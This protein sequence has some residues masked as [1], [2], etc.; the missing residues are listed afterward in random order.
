[1]PPAVLKTKKKPSGVRPAQGGWANSDGL[2]I[3]AIC[4]V[5]AVATIAGIGNDFTSDDLQ[6][7]ASNARIQDLGRW[8]EWFTLP[9]WPPPFSPDLYRPLTSALLA[10]E[11]VL[12]AGSPLVFRLA[13]YLLYAASCV[14]VF[15][16]CKRMMPRGFAL[17][18]ALVFAAHPVHVEAVALGVG[19]SELV[20]A[21]LAI[22]MSVLYIDARRR[23][24][25]TV[26]RWSL[27]ICLYAVACLT[28]EQGFVLPALLIAA[29]F[30]LLSE[31]L[32][33]RL[34]TLWRGFASLAA[35]A[36]IVLLQREHVLGDVR[37]SFTAEALLGLGIGG[38]TLTMLAVVPQWARLFLWPAHLRS[39]YSPQEIVASTG[40]G[41]AEAFGILLILSLLIAGW[42]TRRRA[43]AVTFGLAW[44]ALALAPV[45]NVFVPS[46]IVLAERTLFLPSIGFVIAGAGLVHFVLSARPSLHGAHSRW[47]AGACA[48]VVL[49]GV[50][51]SVERQRVW[52][53]E[54]FLVAR[55]VQDAPR[56]FRMQ[57][58]YGNLLFELDQ[59]QLARAAYARAMQLAPPTVVWRVHN[60]LARAWKL[61]GDFSAEADELRTSLSQL[62]DQE[63]T[64]G[65]LIVAALALG[66]YGDARSEAD[67]G[68][69]HGASATVFG[70]LRALADSAARVKA[71]AGTIK[72]VL[73]LGAPAAQTYVRDR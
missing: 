9:F 66:R 71:P 11:Y 15:A 37:G 1:M 64:R 10:C 41:P 39:D 4:A 20:V 49:L 5:V 48:A 69:V 35:V 27:L 47:L 70:G 40:V 50:A 19:Q 44:C 60:D 34:R 29:E 53:N 61:R 63:S 33:Q 54:G 6:L 31:T 12:G 62:P 32:G 16:L 13:S 67:S 38:R 51:R 14:G 23:G 45:S 42:A 73:H 58:A 52:R 36:V 57:Q 56:S 18:A 43:P 28:K 72:I 25:L 55:G 30:I 8:R 17:A 68:I 59:P 26:R 24:P 2:A 65:E 46:G 22:A 7:I 3:A 21:C